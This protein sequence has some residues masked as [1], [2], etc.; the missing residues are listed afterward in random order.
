MIQIT[1]NELVKK[2]K[3]IARLYSISDCVKIGGVGCVLITSKHNVYLGVSIH[4]CC[5][6]GSCAEHSAIASMVTNGEYKI[7]KI[8]AV[9]SD[10]IILPPCG[11]C[12]EL[13]YQI[14]KEN[15]DADII[16]GGNKTAKLRDLLPDP[17]QKRFDKNRP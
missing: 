6:V 14:N 12:R 1:N 13:M 16:V 15:I 4:A 5:G 8:A 3:K 11:K 7:K 2:A 10:G 9:S 17:W